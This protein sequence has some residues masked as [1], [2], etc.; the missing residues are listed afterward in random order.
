MPDELVVSPQ[1]MVAVISPLLSPGLASVN[2]APERLTD[3]A[4]LP[5]A[6]AVVTPL[7]AASATVAVPVILAVLVPASLTSMVMPKV[8]SSA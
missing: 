8:P 1:W 2:V 3:A 5:V 6:V 4:S 7:R